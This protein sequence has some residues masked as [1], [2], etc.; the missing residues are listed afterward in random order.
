[1]SQDLFQHEQISN[2]TRSIVFVVANFIY[3]LFRNKITQTKL[4]KDPE[5]DLKLLEIS[6]KIAQA[7]IHSVIHRLFNLRCD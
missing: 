2:F 7:V 6:T 5:H 1:M 3:N 4:K